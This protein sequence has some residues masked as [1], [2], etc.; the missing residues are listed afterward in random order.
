[1][2]KLNSLQII[3]AIT[4]L[5]I[6]IYHI[7][8]Y[9][10][11]YKKMDWGLMW[12]KNNGSLLV[13]TFFMLSAFVNV[14]VLL[15]NGRNIKS[16]IIKR[17]IRIYPTY[18]ILFL[19]TFVGYILF[20]G[21]LMASSIDYLAT[22]TLLP[23]AEGYRYALP[24][25]WSLQY[26]V[27]FYA[28]LAVGMLL[29]RKDF[30]VIL[31]VFAFTV[32]FYQSMLA[33]GANYEFNNRFLIAITS[34]YWLFFLFGSFFSLYHVKKDI[35]YLALSI[36]ML[37]MLQ[38]VG[39]MSYFSCGTI[40]VISLLLSKLESADGRFCQFWAKRKL[41]LY[42]AKISYPLYLSY[43][44]VIR[45]LNKV[46]GKY[47]IDGHLWQVVWI[48]SMI[49]ICVVFAAFFYE[50]IEKRVGRFLNRKLIKR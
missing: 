46:W 24:A 37:A 28:I 38:T 17:V 19:T 21:G 48:L 9:M 44:L 4:C 43:I 2:E 32:C 14:Y 11:P 10:D 3:R 31:V 30:Y 36:V 39:K 40:M 35:F 12:I 34:H 20:T 8:A 23:N 18:Y 27:I 22:F 41:I 13:P 29:F 7:S 47:G 1:M 45:V 26:E 15:H 6:V 16:F 33:I 42:I 49:V 50:L 25:S 5:W